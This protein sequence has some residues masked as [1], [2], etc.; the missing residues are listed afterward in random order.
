MFQRVLLPLDG[1]DTAER[2]IP[3]VAC[4]ARPLRS[5]LTLI[6]MLPR[7]GDEDAV[8]CAF[9]DLNRITRQVALTDFRVGTQVR[10]GSIADGVLSAVELLSA[11]LLV[12]ASCFGDARTIVSRTRVP[13]ILV[14]AQTQ[15]CAK[16]ERVLV[17]AN[18]TLSQTQTLA[19]ASELAHGREAEL[20][21]LSAVMHSQD[22]HAVAVAG[23][24]QQANLGEA[25]VEA[26]QQLRADIVVVGTRE[27]VE[28]LPLSFIDAL[29]VPLLLVPDASDVAP[30][31]MRGELG[32]HSDA[33]D[34]A[35]ASY[36]TYIHH[37]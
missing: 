9:M 33:N 2:T 31:D 18:R 10:T 29:G 35:G 21:L 37:R 27:F 17:P 16:I 15:G 11:D 25:I 4:I 20:I 30:S 5:E 7:G 28:W 22:S 34:S 14:P 1:A 12:M 36:T 8:R 26:S 6:G 23:T 24:R 3:V 13:V 19:V 32:V